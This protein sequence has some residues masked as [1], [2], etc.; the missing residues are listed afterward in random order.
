MAEK[1]FYLLIILSVVIGLLLM[2]I[3]I[4]RIRRRQQSRHM[5]RGLAEY[6][7]LKS[8]GKRITKTRFGSDS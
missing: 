7:A 8:S 5:E 4:E 1:Y 2:R 3:V 6:L